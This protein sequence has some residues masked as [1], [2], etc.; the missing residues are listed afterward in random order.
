[1]RREEKESYEGRKRELQSRKMELGS[2]MEE[3]ERRKMRLKEGRT[4]KYEKG[5]TEEYGGKNE[6]SSEIR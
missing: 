4:G 2:K 5:I 3:L 1:M 6:I